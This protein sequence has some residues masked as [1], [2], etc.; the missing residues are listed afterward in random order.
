MLS[1]LVRDI[2]LES[3]WDGG[4]TTGGT[5]NSS[6][7]GGILTVRRALSSNNPALLS[8]IVRLSS[9][10]WSHTPES[11]FPALTQVSD[12]VVRESQGQGP[13]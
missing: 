10:T 1:R 9:L 8:T 3:G 13:G 5:G 2:V 4:S 12:D 11:L 6:I 7:G